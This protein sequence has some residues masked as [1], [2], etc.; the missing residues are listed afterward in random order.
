MKRLAMLVA[1][2]AA[3]IALLVTI[4]ALDGSDSHDQ[5]AAISTPATVPT[6]GGLP[7]STSAAPPPHYRSG[8]VVKDDHTDYGTV[9]LKV[10][11][12]KGRIVRID[13][14]EL[15]HANQVDRQL[16]GP[17]AHTLTSEVLSAQTA[18]VDMVSG[19]TYTSEGYL[20]SLQAALDQLS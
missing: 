14:L 17:A 16:S 5:P 6:S 3:V 20:N 1:A 15:P 7:T 9:R 10:T 2:T 18:S 13:V 11:T 19:A 8:T 4:R 12:K